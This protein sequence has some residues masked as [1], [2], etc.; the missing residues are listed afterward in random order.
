VPVTRLSVFRHAF[1]DD[2][3]RATATDLTVHAV[4]KPSGLAASGGLI[5]LLQAA[6]Q[7]AVLQQGLVLAVPERSVIDTGSRKIVYREA[8]PNV[9][10]GVEIR[11]GPRCGG[12]YPVIHG[13]ELGDRVATAGSFLIDAETRLTGGAGSTYFGASGGPTADRRTARPSMAEDQET[14]IQSSL[15]KLGAADRQLAEAQ[16]YCPILSDNRLGV[17]GVPVKLTLQGQTVFLCCKGCIKSARDNE[18]KTLAKIAELKSRPK[19][20]PSVSTS[21]DSVESEIRANLA[22]L[23]GDDRRLA[24]VQGYCA[25]ITKNRLGAMG[26]PVKIMVKGQPVFLCC[27]GCEEKAQDHPEKTLATVEQLKAKVKAG[28]QP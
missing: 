2:W 19:S 14:M 23:N 9:Y 11:L 13:L 4:A 5:S 7:R 18:A 27:D 24:E 1:T 28:K 10:E 8:A 25:V 12:F 22:K 20:A 3:Q 26:V 6:E 21:S 17:M 16:R 15:A